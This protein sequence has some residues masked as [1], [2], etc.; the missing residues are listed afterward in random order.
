[1]QINQWHCVHGER[2]YNLLVIETPIQSGT[3]VLRIRIRCRAYGDIVNTMVA[4]TACCHRLSKKVIQASMHGNISTIKVAKN[5]APTRRTKHIY[6]GFHYLQDHVRKDDVGSQYIN[7]AEMFGDLF[8]KQVNRLTFKKDTSTLH[9]PPRRNF[10][11]RRGGC[12]D[13][14]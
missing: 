7:T 1:M 4:S 12:Y 3:I 10:R 6:I 14:P 8:T 9:S 13:R 11:L 5:I 2:L